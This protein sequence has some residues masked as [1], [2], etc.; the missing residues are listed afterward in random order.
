MGTVGFGA[1]WHSDMHSKGTLL[2]QEALQE[3]KPE[4]ALCLLRVTFING[5]SVASPVAAALTEDLIL[6]LLLRQQTRAG[7]R[8]EASFTRQ[9]SYTEVQLG[10]PVPHQEVGRPP[11]CCLLWFILAA[12]S[13]A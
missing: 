1:S 10:A 8:A 5:L 11:G 12:P 7:S 9:G 13:L 3:A 6:D 2:F 4:V